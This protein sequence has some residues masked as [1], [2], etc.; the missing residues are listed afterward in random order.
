MRENRMAPPTAIPIMVDFS[1]LRLLLLVEVVVVGELEEEDDVQEM[2]RGNPQR[3]GL[4]EYADGPCL[5]KYEFK[6]MEPERLL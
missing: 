3:S 1:K 2:L 5:L 4:L 6:G